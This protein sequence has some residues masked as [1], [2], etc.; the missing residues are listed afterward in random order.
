MNNDLGDLEFED[1]FPIDLRRHAI[2]KVFWRRISYRKNDRIR[3]S[4]RKKSKGNRRFCFSIGRASSFVAI[5]KI[6]TG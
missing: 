2:A 1:S 6:S 5:S 4:R 3:K